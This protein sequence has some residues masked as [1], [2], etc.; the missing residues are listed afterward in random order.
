VPPENAL[1]FTAVISMVAHG[2]GTRD[3]A[4]VMHTDP[5]A[6]RRHDAMG[7]QDGWGTALDQLVALARTL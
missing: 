2:T 3:T 4:H 1:G 5:D 7:F 6:C